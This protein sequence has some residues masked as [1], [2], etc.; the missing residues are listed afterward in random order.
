MTHAQNTEGGSTSASRFHRTPIMPVGKT[1]NPAKKASAKANGKPAPSQAG[2]TTH[3][4]KKPEPTVAHLWVKHMQSGLEG[5]Y[6]VNQGAFGAP[7]MYRWNDV[8]WE[9]VS[10]DRLKIQVGSWIDKRFPHRATT[11]AVNDAVN[12]A[13]VR[14]GELSPLPQPTKMHIMPVSNAYLVIEEDASI[15]VEKPDRALG[16]THAAKVSVKTP[17]GQKHIPQ[18]VPEH[19]LF[20]QFLAC[21]LP[22]EGER[23]LIQEQCAMTFLPYSLHK[24]IWWYG[25]GR[26]GK[27]V[28]SKLLQKFHARVATASLTK[29]DDA[30]G[31]EQLVGC[32]LIVVDEAPKGTWC[33]EIFK[34][35]VSG[36]PVHVNRKMEKAV[37]YYNHASILI[38]SNP[39]PFIR[40]NSNGVH[41]RLQVVKWTV[42]VPEDKRIHDL[43]QKIFEQEGHIVLDWLLEGLQRIVRRG[44]LMRDHEMPESVRRTKKQLRTANDSVGAWIEDYG[45]QYDAHT[46]NPMTKD[47]VYEAFVEW[48][49]EDGRKVL[50]ANVFWRELSARH[51]FIGTTQ[52][53]TKTIKN[54]RRYVV[55]VSIQRQPK[56]SMP[57]TITEFPNDPIDF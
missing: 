29:L 27:G 30:F 4:K 43:D 23:A 11:S 49:Q 38:T 18:S 56:E 34:S 5:S 51:A 24:A 19:S 8:H 55:N 17:V 41:E 10:P 57:T 48:C 6:A 16:L 42:V 9:E 50:E 53:L 12:Y 1:N 35:L 54:K 52:R 40:D 3:G 46:Q 20:G 45:V 15:R 21:S 37:L 33:E 2:A 32:S 7:I 13:F 44:G 25:E 39:A 47:D 14:F 22:D 31:I 26:N 28:L 36:D